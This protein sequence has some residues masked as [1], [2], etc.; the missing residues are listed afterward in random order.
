MK[1]QKTGDQSRRNFLK[2]TSLGSFALVPTV[3]TLAKLLNIEPRYIEDFFTDEFHYFDNNLT[4]LHFYFINAKLTGKLLKPVKAGELAYMIVKIP[5]QHIAEQVIKETDLQNY[6]DN[7]QKV[8]SKISGFS[9]LAFHVFPKVKTISASGI[10]TITQKTQ[11]TID[12]PSKLLNWANATNFELII[13]KK[14]DFRSFGGSDWKAF[15]ANNLTQISDTDLNPSS[16]YISKLYQDICSKIFKASAYP[17][18]V[19]EIPEGLL[20]SPYSANGA[21]AFVDNYQIGKTRFLIDDDNKRVIRTVEEIWSPSLFF[22]SINGPIDPSLRAIGYIP[23]QETSKDR[24]KDECPKDEFTFLP[25]LL[26]K[27]ELVYLTSLGRGDNETTDW[28]IETKGLTF[29]GLGA[30]AKFHYKNL[31]PP[32]D[33][34]LAEYE[35]HITMGRDEYIKVARLGVISV[36][37]QRAMHVRI[38]QRKIVKGESYMDFK[39]YIEIVQKDINYFDNRLFVGGEQG[40]EIKEPKNYIHART[41]PSV[42]NKPNLVIHSIDLPSLE[43]DNTY[44]DSVLWN[45][46]NY[47]PN[48]PYPAA[49]AQ[50]NWHTHYRRWPFKRIESVTLISKPIETDK[51]KKPTALTYEHPSCDCATVFWPVLEKQLDNQDQDCYLDFIGYDWNNQAIKFSSTFLFIRK[52]IIEC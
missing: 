32:K 12:K 43:T 4:N 35:H 28:N 8:Q 48:H 49:Q 29:T 22:E 9:Y 41:Y 25:S 1:N 24:S 27:K 18:T 42:Y 37:G 6:T 34:D 3:N 16:G 39:E 13:P 26:D 20:V 31:T 2:L 19:L 47:L 51:A 30:I 46:P 33:T 14:D 40:K 23:R 36:T 38:G 52:K 10:T 44:R 50:M 11:L 7:K 21:R 17:I 45:L 15:K 5:Q